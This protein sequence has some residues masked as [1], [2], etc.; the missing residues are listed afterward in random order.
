MA[1]IC[2]NSHPAL[3]KRTSP[4]QQKPTDQVTTSNEIARQKRAE[5]S[6]KIILCKT[7]YAVLRSRNYLFSAPAPPLSIISAPAPAPATAIYCYL[8]LFY[9]SI[10]ILIE[11]EISFS[12]S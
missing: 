9:N 3:N 12:S 10:T 8:K 7:F 1:H 4:D 11:V 6:L 2:S 5:K